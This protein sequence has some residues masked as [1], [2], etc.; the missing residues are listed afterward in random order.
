MEDAQRNDHC[1][2]YFKKRCGSAPISRPPWSGK[3]A[4]AGPQSFL[5]S[6]GSPESLGFRACRTGGSGGESL[7]VRVVSYNLYW[8]NAF[9]QN[10]WSLG[11]CTTLST[12]CGQGVTRTSRFTARTAQEERPHH[13]EHQEHAEARFHRP[14]GDLR[15]VREGPKRD[16]AAARAQECDE[17][18]TIRDRAGLERA[19][20]FDGAQ[21]IMVKPG[22]VRRPSVLGPRSSAL[23][24]IRCSAGVFR[25]GDSGSRD[26]QARLGPGLVGPRRREWGP[27]SGHRQMGSALR[28]LGGVDRPEERSDFLALQ[29]PLAPCVAVAVGA[30]RLCR[31]F[32]DRLAAQVCTQWQRPGL[33]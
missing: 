21:G 30:D 19:S 18:Q 16:S 9:G 27:A 28:D 20:K 23:C 6:P 1:S 7:K 26:I 10:P 31:V 22:Q 8:W 15:R 12:A 14:A 4:R 5:G 32:L 11:R 17:P 24:P 25:K 29:H 3:A 33:Q 2:S 13:S